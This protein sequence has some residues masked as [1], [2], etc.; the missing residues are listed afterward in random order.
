[1][2]CFDWCPIG[3]RQDRQQGRLDKH[4][5]FHPL[6]EAAGE[7]EGSYAAAGMS[8]QARAIKALGVEDGSEIIH[9]TRASAVAGGQKAVATIVAAR[10]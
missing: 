2:S 10:A 6:W 9:T 1:V 4:E 5:V 7:Y 3:W 8:E